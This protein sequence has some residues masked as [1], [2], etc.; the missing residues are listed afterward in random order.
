[1]REATAMDSNER[2]LHGEREAAVTFAEFGNHVDAAISAVHEERRRIERDLHDGVQQRLAVLA[3]KLE[4]AREQCAA[5]QEV[6]SAMLLPLRVE[7][8]EIIDEIRALGHGVYPSILRERGLADALRAAAA[9]SPLPARVDAVDDTR[10]PAEVEAAVY[11][12]CLEALQNAAKHARAT[13]VSI[14]LRGTGALSFA[15]ADDGAGFSERSVEPGSGLR[16]MRE[17]LAE[18]GGELAVESVPGRG[19]RISGAVPASVATRTS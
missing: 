4:L 1:M 14:T 13:Q 17:R 19:T 16:N 3:I 11:F 15:V 7:V 18:V 10:Y 12:V 8:C 2:E 9:R 6:V 5:S